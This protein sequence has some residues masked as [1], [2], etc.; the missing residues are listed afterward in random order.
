MLA[1]KISGDAPKA[2]ISA[3][4]HLVEYTVYSLAKLFNLA[5]YHRLVCYLQNPT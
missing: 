2:R 1:V 5:N 3:S 4:L